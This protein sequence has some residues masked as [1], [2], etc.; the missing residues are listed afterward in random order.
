MRRLLTFLYTVF[1]LFNALYAEGNTLS[2]DQ[3]SFYSWENAAGR[4]EKNNTRSGHPALQLQG[5]NGGWS[6]TVPVTPGLIHRFRCFYRNNA[7]SGN[8]TLYVREPQSNG[9]LKT[10]VYKPQ[11]I[12]PADRAGKFVD[13]VYVG[14]ADENGWVEFDGGSFIPGPTT[15]RINLLLKLRGENQETRLL[16]DEIRLTATPPRN[17]PE[18]AQLLRSGTFGT[19]WA[20]SENRKVLPSTTPPKN[21]KAEPLS[22]SAAGG[23][24]ESFQLIFTPNRDLKDVNWSWNAPTGPAP[25]SAAQLRCRNVEWI[26]IEKTTGPYGHTG[27][28]PDPLTD[29]L[30]CQIEKGQNQAFWFTLH[31][32]PNQ[33]AGIYSAILKLTIEEKQAAEIPLTLTVRNFSI[34]TKPSIETRSQ[35]RSQL[36]L[37]REQ[38][39][40]EEVLTHYMQ[41]FYAHR[42]ECHPP[43]RF[44]LRLNDQRA[45]LN[46][47]EC[48]QY[49]H[50][51]KKLGSTRLFIPCLWIEHGGSHKMPRNAKWQGITI[52]ENDEMTALNPAFEA[53]FRDFMTQLCQR[54]RSEELFIRPTVKFIDEPV[55]SDPAT[56]NGIKTLATL[57]LDIEPQL[58]IRTAANY[59][60]PDLTGLIKYWNLHTDAWDRNQ[61]Y[62]E[63]ARK[64][65]CFISVYNNAVN[66]PEH[67]F[68]RVRL[69]PWLLWKYQVDGS[70]SWW[71]TVCWR[72]EAVDPWTAG[73]SNSGILLYPPRTPEENGP[74]DSIRWELLRE[75]LEDYEY[76]RLTSDLVQQLENQGNSRAAQIGKKALAYVQSLVD[77]WPNVKAEND[78]PYCI[79][80]I[81]VKNARVQLASAI[82]SMQQ[83]LKK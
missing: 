4:I 31:I 64:A 3:W 77:H 41:N 61:H 83:A 49:L 38:G 59:P 65:G 36:V 27:L 58:T 55:F 32:P 10:I 22:I 66:L 34:P 76:M 35:F 24:Y 8:L 40:R 37:N 28:N 46:M 14:G 75:G 69:W 56:I 13:G 53:L 82:E 18:S 5:I 11:P 73:K 42:T 39:G 67:R 51:A 72:G 47:D 7:G 48:I 9:K 68:L 6:T 52:F 12:I 19:I 29:A 74:I 63:A 70:Y 80:P 50:L 33:P 2:A 20:E 78:E 23:E 62:I 21:K 45:E 17:P 26:P 81:D 57:M 79:N 44:N 43:G 30:P 71:G 54:L 16:I 15:T 60:H 1:L 25:L